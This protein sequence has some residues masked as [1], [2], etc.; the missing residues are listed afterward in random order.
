MCLFPV[1]LPLLKV[2][3][4][5]DNFCFLYVVTGYADLKDKPSAA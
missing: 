3:G 4:G 1:P 2:L 5:W